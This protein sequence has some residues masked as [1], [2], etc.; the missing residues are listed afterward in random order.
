MLIFCLVGCLSDEGWPRRSRAW[1]CFTISRNE[2][3]GVDPNY[4]LIINVFALFVM[5][6]KPMLLLEVSKGYWRFPHVVV[7]FIFVYFLSVMV[8]RWVQVGV[9]T[10]TRYIVCYYIGTCVLY[11][12]AKLS[13]PTGQKTSKFRKQQEKNFIS[14]NLILMSIG[15]SGII[16]FEFQTT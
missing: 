1:R 15:K 8:C 12:S 6:T 11:H 9:F 3:L 2:E 5:F 14:A 4:Y 16:K 13:K 10:F 7:P